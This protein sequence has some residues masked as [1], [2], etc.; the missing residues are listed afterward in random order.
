M[1][2]IISESDTCREGN[3]TRQ[4]N[5][6]SGS[7]LPAKARRE[8]RQRRKAEKCTKCHLLKANPVPGLLNTLSALTA[9]LGEL[10]SSS[11][12]DAEKF[13]EVP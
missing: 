5:Q 7:K 8:V 1:N 12:I 4:G 2:Q 6:T 10:L 11:F 13:R 3:Y 9:T